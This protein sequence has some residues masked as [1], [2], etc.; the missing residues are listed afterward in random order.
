MACPDLQWDSLT[1]ILRLTAFLWIFYLNVTAE[2][3]G[4]PA[5]YSGGPRFHFLPTNQILRPTFPAIC[6]A[7]HVNAE[8]V[9][10]NR[11]RPLHST[12]YRTHRPHNT[13]IL[14]STTYSDEWF[15]IYTDLR[16]TARQ[17][18][19]QWSDGRSSATGE[20]EF[21]FF[22]L[23][24]RSAVGRFLSNAIKAAVTWRWSV[25]DTQNACCYFQSPICLEG[26]VTTDTK[27]FKTRVSNGRCLRPQA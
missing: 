24:V 27:N 12:S 7:S 5:I 3:L 1:F 9:Q 22:V 21:F 10:W 8:M 18:R 2:W 26:E 15:V 6:L 14:C 16:Q 23:A 25:A 20:R 13:P 17:D 4:I 11:S 19:S